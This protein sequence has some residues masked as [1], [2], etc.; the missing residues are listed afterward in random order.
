MAQQLQEYATEIKEWALGLANSVSDSIQE[1]NPV[2]ITGIAV[3]VVF[4]IVLLIDGFLLKDSEFGMVE[5]IQI[6][7][8]SIIDMVIVA[9]DKILGMIRNAFGQAEQRQAPKR[10]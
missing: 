9:K 3:P 7:A 1:G 4:A 5:T 2:V 10:K 6:L 8:L